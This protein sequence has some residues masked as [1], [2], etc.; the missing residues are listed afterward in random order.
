MYRMHL[1]PFYKNSGILGQIVNNIAHFDW[2][3]VSF[4][5]KVGGCFDVLIAIGIT[6][7]H[8]VAQSKFCAPLAPALG[9]AR[10]FARI[11]RRR[12]SPTDKPT[13]PSSHEPPE[14]TGKMKYLHSEETLDIPE[15]G[16]NNPSPESTS[17]ISNA[18]SQTRQQPAR[19]REGTLREGVHYGRANCKPKALVCLAVD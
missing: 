11:L 1:Q 13:P 18:P 9:R 17:I 2:A 15:G 4:G 12:P 14:S 6:L 19:K 7:S 10:N 8:V 5:R 16:T 3:E